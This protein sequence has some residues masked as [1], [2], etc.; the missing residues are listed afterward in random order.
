LETHAVWE[1]PMAF[2]E[3]IDIDVAFVSFLPRCRPMPRDFLRQ[4]EA[5]GRIL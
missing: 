5:H 4:P 1:T 3:A 2:D